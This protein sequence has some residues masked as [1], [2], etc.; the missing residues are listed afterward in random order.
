MLCFVLAKQWYENIIWF[1]CRIISRTLP[2]CPSHSFPWR[3][4]G[5]SQQNTCPLV[6][7]LRLTC[8]IL[9]TFLTPSQVEPW[10]IPLGYAESAALHGADILLGR[11]V[12]AAEFDDDSH[13]W[14]LTTNSSDVASTGRSPPGNVVF[15]DGGNDDAASAVDAAA[16]VGSVTATVVINCAGLYG[17]SVE[18]FRLDGA[19]N[20]SVTTASTS[21]SDPGEEGRSAPPW[22]TVTPR[23]GQFL[24]YAAPET[25]TM[26]DASDANNNSSGNSELPM[27]IIEP[28]AT[29]FT[30]GVIVWVNLHGNIVVGPTATDQPSKT[31]RSTDVETV[32]MLKRWGE[33][34]IPALEGSEILGT[35]SGLR[36]ATEHRDYQ[37]V[38]HPEQNWV[39]VA[40]IRS[41]G[42]TASSGIAEYVAGLY[43]PMLL[44]PQ[45]AEGG[46][47]GQKGQTHRIIK[48]T[49]WISGQE[50]DA[51]WLLGVTEASENPE[52]LDP[53]VAVE[54]AAIPP[55]ELLAAEYQTRG[56]GI[57]TVF[58]KEWRVAHPIAS[59]GFE[60]R[61]L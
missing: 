61:S 54:N 46:G 45:K 58:N 44:P 18:R 15:D 37:I 55:L 32:A 56:D 7:L 60:S 53:R 26:G 36:P 14:K 10:L 40:G 11:N 52:P 8:T 59:F 38:S 49:Q 47:Q 31:D 2:G 28:V 57:V 21:S 30:K 25:Q 3:G 43:E 50:Q 39:T 24:V 33:K 16:E 51:D 4:N 34:V 29:Q 13:R 20:G 19:H 5:A 22:F 27:H 17:D 12:V 42:L 41:T 48:S 6:D 9:P 23:K 1:F 35:Y